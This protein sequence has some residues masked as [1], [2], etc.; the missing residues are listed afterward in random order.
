MVLRNHFMDNMI[1]FRFFFYFLQKYIKNTKTNLFIFFITKVFLK[2]NNYSFFFKK[3]KKTDGLQGA[4]KT[5]RREINYPGKE[6]DGWEM[7]PSEG[8]FSLSS[9]QVV[10]PN[11]SSLTS[12]MFD[13]LAHAHRISQ[14]LCKINEKKLFA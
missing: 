3:K 7:G 11:S 8:L 14:I 6:R 10:G 12:P 4:E 13:S 1:I 9:S 5:R 2:C